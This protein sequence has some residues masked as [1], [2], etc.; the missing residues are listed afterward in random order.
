MKDETWQ[1]RS[2]AYSSSFRFLPSVFVCMSVFQ[3][4]GKRGMTP[5]HSDTLS[6]IEARIDP[7][8]YSAQFDAIREL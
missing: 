5:M 2:E 7:C 4:L 3:Q 1:M 8:R 6:I